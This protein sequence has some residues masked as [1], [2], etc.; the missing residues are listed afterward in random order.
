MADPMEHDNLINRP[1]LKS[2]INRLSAYIPNHDEPEIMDNDF[3]KKRFRRTMAV[4]NKMGPEYRKQ[5]DR[6][7]LDPDFVK[8]VYKKTK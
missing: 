6:G 1:D 3:D 2:V 8:E 4:I 5:A 7:E